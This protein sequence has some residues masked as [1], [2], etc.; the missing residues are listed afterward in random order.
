[1]EGGKKK[2]DLILCV[3]TNV[4][5]L[6]N[7]SQVIDVDGLRMFV[8]ELESLPCTLLALEP[9]RVRGTVMCEMGGVGGG[10][11]VVSL[12]VL[13]LQERLRHTEAFQAKAAEELVELTQFFE[14]G[15]FGSI[16]QL[17]QLIK[18][19]ENLDVEMEQLAELKNVN[20]LPYL[21]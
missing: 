21:C 9:L 14:N 18:S 8:K 15:Q 3:F 19:G 1:M 16:S 4:L 5:R 17:E 13:L 10:G 7:G 12:M 11:T 2:T 20:Y 6:S